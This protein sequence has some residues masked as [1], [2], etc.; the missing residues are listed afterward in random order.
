MT[1]SANDPSAAAGYY[2]P[3]LS[4]LGRQPGPPFRIEIPFTG[5]HW[6]AFEVASR[7]PLARGWE[8][9]LDIKYNHLFYGGALTPATYLAW[10]HKLGIRYVAVSDAGLDYSAKRERMLRINVDAKNRSRAVK[11]LVSYVAEHIA[12]ADTQAFSR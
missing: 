6:E 2:R 10:L 8:R 5:F 11:I 7:F 9:Q 12:S 4:F 3:L 1:E